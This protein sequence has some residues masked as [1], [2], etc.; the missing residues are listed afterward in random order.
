MIRTQ[1]QLTEVQAEN[2]KRLAIRQQISMAALIRQA[3]DQ[4]FHPGLD[5][6]RQANFAKALN[7]A[8]K[9]HSGQHDLSVN[10]D[11]YLSEAFKS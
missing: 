3:I 5:K 9:F 1:I 11:Q 7:A 4:M 8:G 2:L 10:H 6:E